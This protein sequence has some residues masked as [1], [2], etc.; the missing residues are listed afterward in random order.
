[1]KPKVSTV[2]RIRVVVWYCSESPEFAPRRID[3]KMGGDRVSGLL[4]WLAVIPTGVFVGLEAQVRSVIAGRLRVYNAVDLVVMTSFYHVLFEALCDAVLVP[5]AGGGRRAK[6]RWRGVAQALVT[7]FQVGRAVHIAADAIHTYGTEVH[8]EHRSRVPP[9]MLEL[10]YFL[11]EDL[12]HWLLFIPYYALLALLTCH[13]D[14]ADDSSAGEGRSRRAGRSSSPARLL[15]AK[16]ER[17]HSR[18]AAG[19]VALG[20]L[21]R[22]STER[23]VSLFRS[24]VGPLNAL[25]DLLLPAGRDGAWMVRIVLAGGLMGATHAVA[26]IESTHW[27]L[28]IYA[29]LVLVASAFVAADRYHLLCA[30][31]CLYLCFCNAAFA[32][33]MRRRRWWWSWWCGGLSKRRRRRGK[34]G[35]RSP[36]RD[37]STAPVDDA[38]THSRR[39]TRTRRG[40][41]S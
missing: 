36:K 25:F 19:E 23:P 20:L 22:F 40:R 34:C 41:C 37:F 29:A 14:D 9:D 11:D 16:G 39:S 28:G 4:C 7:C 35:S 31:S 1:M 24:P 12:G 6:H 38:C 33:R 26:V 17:A 13:Y 30:L 10:I 21:S 32:W 15:V 2:N 5:E 8:P 3:R 27:W 18:R